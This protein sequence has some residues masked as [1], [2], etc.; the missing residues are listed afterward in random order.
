MWRISQSVLDPRIPPK[1]PKILK[2]AAGMFRPRAHRVRRNTAERGEPVS[3]TLLTGAGRSVG[4]VRHAG[5]SRSYTHGPRSDAAI[6]LRESV[7]GT[8]AWRP[9]CGGYTSVTCIPSADRLNRNPPVCECSLITTPFS[10]LSQATEPPSN[11]VRP[12]VTAVKLPL[13]IRRTGQ[14]VDLT[15]GVEPAAP[16]STID[17]PESLNLYCFWS[18]L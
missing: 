18:L 2:S 1:S 10:F 6:D 14:I 8:G 7:S 9:T 11:I 16:T 3:R 13:E 4:N 12:A 5:P 15:L 17:M